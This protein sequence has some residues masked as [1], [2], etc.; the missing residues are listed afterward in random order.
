MAAQLAASQEG[1]NSVHTVHEMLN[2]ALTA[3]FSGGSFINHSFT[4]LNGEL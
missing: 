1:L 3:G 2:W 4:N